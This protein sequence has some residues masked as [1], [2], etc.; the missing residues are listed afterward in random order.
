MRWR[1]LTGNRQSLLAAALIIFLI[2]I[3][4]HLIIKTFADEPEIA[5]TLGEPWEDMRQRSSAKVAPAPPNE[6]WFRV[7]ESDAHL[8]FIDPQYGFITPLARYFTIGFRQERVRNISLSPQ[9][10]ALL[11]DDALNVVLDLQMQWREKGWSVSRPISD[12]PI[13]DTPQ[14]RAQLRSVMGGRT[15][16]HAEDKYQV[17]LMLNRFKDSKRPDEE[18]YLITLELSRPW[19]PIE[20]D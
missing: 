17:M 15:F 7:P 6:T 16:W 19:I 2:F 14:W 5:L 1:T 9:V 3:T 12:P 18:R 4:A 20:T 13:A 8:R 10:E 11:L